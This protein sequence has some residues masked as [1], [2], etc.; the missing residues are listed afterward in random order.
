VVREYAHL[1]TGGPGDVRSDFAETLYWNPVLI[2]PDGEADAS[3]DLCDSV[4]TFQV[5][6]AGHTTDG[7]LGAVVTELESRLPLTAEP[8]L[9]IEVTASDKLAIPVS[10]AN[11][12]SV[13]QSVAVRLQANGLSVGADP[14]AQLNLAP[15]AR[16][17]HVY[18][19]QPTIQEGAAEIRI[20]AE[21]ASMAADRVVRSLRIVPDG[22]PVSGVQSD[23]LDGV[24]VHDFTLPESWMAGTLKY[25]VAAYPSTLADLQKGLESLLREPNGCFEQTSSSNY[26]NLLTLDYLQETD[27]A[28]P[29]L[30]RRAKDMLGRGYQKLTSFECLNRAASRREGY[31]WF[32]GTA[33][34]HEA[35]TA[36]GL[37]QFRDM[38]RVYDVDRDMVERTKTY[39]LSRRDHKGGFLRNPRGLDH[40]GH[41]PDNI[42]N[43]YIVWAL[44]ENSKEDD[45]TQELDTLAS[46][47]AKSKDPYFL[48]LVAN[49]LL[50][51]DR[52]DDALSLLTSLSKAQQKDGHLDAAQTSITGS[53][54]RDLQIETTALSLLAWLKAKRPDQ[55]NR[56]VE[57]AVR[58]LGQQRGGYGGFGATQSTVLALKALIAH[59]RENKKTVEAGDIV[60]SVG[61]QVVARHHFEAGAQEALISALDDAEKHL[62]PGKN[63]VRIEVSGRNA[64]PYTASW[65]CQAVTPAS[66]D[67]CPLALATSLDRTTAGEGETVRLSITL[68]NK[69]DQGHGMVVAVIGLPA[70]LTLPED[71]KQLKEMARLRNNETEP[72]P[73]SAWE[74]RGRELVLYWRDLGPKQEIQLSLELICRVPGE[75]RG[76]ASRAYLYYNADHKCWVKPLGIAIQAK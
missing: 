50:N 58:W 68:R 23:L 29:E 55:F 59:A 49:S 31:E 74:T 34:P 37:M 60:L 24:A 33:P 45:V 53:G 54:G 51:R 61:D 52:S 20:D 32:G 39:L 36:Y 22:F 47:A 17:R 35:L 76:P 40:F 11:N 71:M 4:T 62:K 48:A 25:Q 63:R 43:A 69:T 13:D 41:A 46:Q 66:G 67:Q 42:T 10:V 70:G 27:Q 19:L 15:N 1:R 30:A 3:F 21:A 16:V 18:R 5:L 44:T 8:K 28:R 26:P 6:V 73:I 14:V 75:Y 9:P 56:S 64:F 57:S 7:R 38:A 65:S 2:L 72:G 12:T